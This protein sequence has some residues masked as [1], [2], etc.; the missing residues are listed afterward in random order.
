MVKLNG[1]HQTLERSEWSADVQ[2]LNAAVVQQLIALVGLQGT[3]GHTVQLFAWRFKKKKKHIKKA[4][5]KTH[6]HNELSKI[7][8]WMSSLSMKQIT[9]FSLEFYQGR[10]KNKNK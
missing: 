8:F 2:E 6:R 4:R 9:F 10:T 3:H 1:F 7:N 5:S